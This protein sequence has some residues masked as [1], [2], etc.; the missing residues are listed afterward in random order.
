MLILQGARS[1]ERDRGDAFRDL[2]RRV[3]DADTV[4]RHPLDLDAYARRRYV[5]HTLRED[6]Q[7][8]ILN[9]PEGAQSKFDKLAEDVYD[10][11]RGTALLYYRDYAGTDGHLP[12]VVTLGDVHPENFGV[13]PNED[14]APV[15]GVN[16]FDEA[17]FA[18]F[19]YDVKRGAVGFWL[20]CRR[21]GFKKKVCRRV[22]RA[23]A[24][25]YLD[26]LTDFA[27]DDAEKW[28]EYRIDNSPKMIR[29]LLKGA[30]Q[31]RA[32]FLSEYLDVAKGRFRSTEEIVPHSKHVGAF[33]E[34]V[35]RYVEANGIE[36][37]GQRA[38]YFT[39][40]DVAIK[41]GSGTASLGLDR[42]WVLLEGPDPDDPSE[43]RL[44]E[45]KQARASALTGLVPP[46]A[47]R[48]A[49]DDE[50]QTVVRAQQVHL[51][52]GDPFY[53][54]AEIDG[55]LFVA[56]ERSPFKDDVDVED[57]S[58]KGMTTYADICGRALAQ[59]H[60]RS[61]ED[62]GVM[63]GAAEREILKAVRPSVFVADVTDFA[64]AAAR[65]VKRDWKA[66]KRDHACGAFDF[67]HG[68]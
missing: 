26:G 23:F 35:D 13:M 38:G 44:L 5:R 46:Q 25:G 20:A 59:P 1:P 50:A 6:H 58:E 52:G 53:G 31:P 30:T 8:R 66:F 64:Q 40:C 37:Y 28:H 17:A 36:V 42:F 32:D 10:F 41:K 60:A 7:F 67:A 9:R 33:Q 15:F 45:F 48:E 57:L 62:T 55:Q 65:R 63:E 18:P 49:D 16:D 51:V 68:E 47:D 21:N 11:F 4:A 2:A 39:V 56:R 24:Q 27:R 19:S 22:V 12:A 3:A 29:K 14:G 34:V 43:A 54:K 61:D